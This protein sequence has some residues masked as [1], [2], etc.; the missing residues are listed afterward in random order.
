MPERNPRLNDTVSVECI[1]LKRL[2]I[3]EYNETLY[4]VKRHGSPELSTSLPYAAS[5]L[6]HEER[7]RAL[8]SSKCNLQLVPSPTVNNRQDENDCPE[9]VHERLGCVAYAQATHNSSVDSRTSR[10]AK[11]DSE[12][13][14]PSPAANDE[15]SKL[16]W[17][18]V[19]AKKSEKLQEEEGEVLSQRYHLERR[20]VA[21][22]VSRILL[23]RFLV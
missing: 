10:G 2:R 6:A 11:L 13:P 15:Y 16:P 1:L 3:Q 7:P 21:T 12:C 4:E 19:Q 5:E 17:R 14:S 18:Q 9:C 8:E 20:K 22:L 23:F